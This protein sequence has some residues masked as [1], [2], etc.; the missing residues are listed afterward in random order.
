MLRRRGGVRALRGNRAGA[1]I[2]PRHQAAVDE[3]LRCKREGRSETILFNL[4]GHG[5]FDMGAYMAYFAGQLK[6]EPY[7][8]DA[9]DSALAELPQ[10][11]A[12]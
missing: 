11:A 2:D 9:L 1:G 12:E 5:H 6:D 7:D 4:S 8:Q 10:V 3:A